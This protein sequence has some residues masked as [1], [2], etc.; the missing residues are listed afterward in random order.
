MVRPGVQ[1]AGGKRRWMVSKACRPP[2]R[3]TDGHGATV[4]DENARDPEEEMAA[5]AQLPRE[6]AE[7]R[8]GA[9]RRVA[10]REA[11]GS[12][13]A[14]LGGGGKARRR[15]IGRAPVREGAVD[16]E[17]AGDARLR[18]D[19]HRAPPRRRDVAAAA[20]GV[21]GEAA[22]RVPLHAVL[23]VL[24]AVA[25]PAAA[26]DA[27]GGP[28]GREALCPPTRQGAVDL[29]PAAQREALL[30]RLAQRANRRAAGR[31]ERPDDAAVRREPAA[32]L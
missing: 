20:P 6:R 28:G 24:P 25:E 8:R 30:P 17:P 4:H 9:E 16:G 2:T 10:G 18:V 1:G 29:G 31:S 5:E 22:R 26:V 13:G 11:G 14:G 32:A 21:P 27:A 3:R 7:R 12:G 19:R 23:C 15:S